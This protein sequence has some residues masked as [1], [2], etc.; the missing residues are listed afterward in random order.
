L[1][2]QIVEAKLSKHRVEVRIGD[3]LTLEHQ[4]TSVAQPVR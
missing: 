3:A 1:V 2:G 4:Q